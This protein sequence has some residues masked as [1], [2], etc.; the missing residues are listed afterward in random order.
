MLELHCLHLRAHPDHPDAPR[1]H[2]SAIL[3]MA[4]GISTVYSRGGGKPLAGP[5]P[6]YVVI[7]A[8]P[9]ISKPII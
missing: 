9:Q 1:R 3:K 7:V 4:N 6:F 5:I 8:L 2:P